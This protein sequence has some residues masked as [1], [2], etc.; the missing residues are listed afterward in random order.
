MPTLSVT[1]KRVF[2]CIYTHYL[3]LQLRE[4]SIFT[5]WAKGFKLGKSKGVG[6]NTK[7]SKMLLLPSTHSSSGVRQR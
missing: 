6:K 1:S 3:P 7:H 5:G 4:F 2:L